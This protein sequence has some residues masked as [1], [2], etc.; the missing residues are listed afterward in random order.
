MDKLDMRTMK[1]QCRRWLIF[2]LVLIMTAGALPAPPVQAAASVRLHFDDAADVSE[3]NLGAGGGQQ[4]SSISLDDTLFYGS[5]AIGQSVKMADRLDKVYRLKILDAFSGLDVTPGKTYTISARV[6]VNGASPVKAGLFFL[7]VMDSTVPQQYTKAADSFLATDQE[8]AELKMTYTVGD[9]P[10]TGI[11]VEQMYAGAYN[12]VVAVVNV[13]EVVVSEYQEPGEPE[14]PVVSAAVYKGTPVIDGQPDAVW[15]NA[16][17]IRTDIFSRGQSGATAAAK[18]LWDETAVYVLASVY[19]PVRSVVN[20]LAHEQDSIEI[21]LDEDNAKSVT[22]D[23][24]DSHYRINY[25]NA[26]SF[27]GQALQTFQSGASETEYGYLVEAAIPIQFVQ[28]EPGLVMGFELQ[29]NDDPGTGSRQSIAKWHDP[30]NNSFKDASGWGTIVLLDSSLPG[31]GLNI[32]AYMNGKRLEFEAGELLRLDGVVMAPAVKLLQAFRAQTQWDPQTE[33]ATAVKGSAVLELSSGSS[34]ALLDGEPVELEASAMLSEQGVLMA[35]VSMLSLLGATVDWDAAAGIVRIRTNDIYVDTSRERQDIWGFG[36]S[37]NNPVHD[38]M[39]FPDVQGKEIILE[40]L[41]GTTG[42]SA[43]LTVVRLEVNPFQKTDPIPTNA[44]QATALP[45]EGVWDWDTDAHQIWFSNEAISRGEDVRFYA[46]PWSAPAW[47]KDNQSEINGGHLL[48]EYYDTYADY[49][50]TWV[51]RYRNEHGFDIKWLSVQNEPNTIVKYASAAYTYEEMDTVAGKVAD[52]VHGA[53]LPVMVGAPE[54]NTKLTTFDYLTHM[55]EETRS[56]LDFIP[57]HSYGGHTTNLSGFGKPLFQTEVSSTAAND[58]SIK[59][60]VDNAKQIAEALSQGYHGWLR[61]WFVTPTNTNSGEALVQLRSDGTYSFNKRLYTMGQFSRFIRPGDV[62]VEAES[63]FRS[64]HVTAAKDPITG[65]A[66]V[67]VINDSMASI[68]SPV[69]GFS[70]PSVDIYRTS[71]SEDLVQQESRT[72]ENGA[73]SYTFPAQSVTT[74]VELED[75]DSLGGSAALS[76]PAQAAAGQT[77]TLTYSMH[78]VTS[79][80]YAQSAIIHFDPAVLEYIGAESLMN[81]VTV[82]DSVYGEGRVKLIAYGLGASLTGT[83]DVIRLQF[84]VLPITGTMNSTIYLSDVR[85]A[86]GNGDIEGIGGGEPNE[87]T[88][89]GLD[90]TALLA[91]LAEAKAGLEA[92]AFSAT[93]W[94]HYPQSALETLQAAVDAAEAVAGGAASQ[95]EAN[96][97]ALSLHTAMESFKRSVNRNRDIGDLAVMGRH[98]L[99]TGG[100][101]TWRQVRMY[102]HNQDGKLDMDDISAFIWGMMHE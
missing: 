71:A 89:Y 36:G 8:W 31:G 59:D 32:N 61:W 72:L 79:S 22:L 35:P 101:G 78:D 64:L 9:K 23:S 17:E 30:T 47:M 74:F 42:S 100:D 50:K 93:L 13:D 62:V 90:L 11:T 95:A 81:Q 63:G 10:I 38:L 86:D 12:Q 48:P 76:G 84:R 14:T 92:A 43:G 77:L 25:M 58:P 69:Y 20:P 70:A 65:K 44:L 55:S 49:L 97:A 45:A 29:V 39:N 18:L 85:V 75:P 96:Q 19:D 7:S 52:A 66:A 16:T 15:E 60:G 94:G 26:R 54:G 68:E 2:L 21:F 56:K 88:V 98:Y 24:N 5:A 91:K 1:A 6:R 34:L 40:K 46:V 27:G 67:V 51:E 4:M 3:A 41:F 82:T 102:D 57:T 73:L 37:A 80:V 28:A 87:L 83:K 53:G 99:A 33:K